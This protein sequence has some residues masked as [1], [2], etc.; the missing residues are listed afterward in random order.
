MQCEGVVFDDYAGDRITFE[1]GAISNTGIHCPWHADG[2]GCHGI[3]ASG[4]PHHVID[5]VTFS[6]PNRSSTTTRSPAA[7]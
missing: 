5:G 6:A 2:S 1:G 7:R 3:Y 4:G